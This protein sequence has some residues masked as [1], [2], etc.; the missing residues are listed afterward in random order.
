M[1]AA[2]QKSRKYGQFG[3]C[4][5]TKPCRSC[6]WQLSHAAK[7]PISVPPTV[8]EARA[9]IQKWRDT[10]NVSKAVLWKMCIKAPMYTVGV[11]PMLI[12]AALAYMVTGHFADAILRDLLLGAVLVIAW[13]NTRY[14][15]PLTHAHRGTDQAAFCTQ[16]CLHTSRCCRAA[17]IRST[18]CELYVTTPFVSHTYGLCSNDAFDA[19]TGVDNI[20]KPESIV[21]LTGWSPRLLVGVAFGMLALGAWRMTVALQ[22]CQSFAPGVML[23]LAVSCGYIYQGPPF[24]C[25]P[26]HDQCAQ[27]RIEVEETCV[28][29]PNTEQCKLRRTAWSEQ[30]WRDL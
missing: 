15:I 7:S 30:R 23:A 21:S 28:K 2:L 9:W 3:T 19:A 4:L 6:G 20:S 8:A 17:C 12:G 26:V 29:A 22:A 27:C 1:Q 25:E 13:L 16:G 14:A 11:A 5:Q 10:G 24:R 18:Q